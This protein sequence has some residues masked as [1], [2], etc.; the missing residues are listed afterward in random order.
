MRQKGLII[1]NK[2][3]T[4]IILDFVWLWLCVYAGWIF[5]LSLSVE[6]KKKY[7]IIKYVLK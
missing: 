1:T 6:K 3:Y 5:F 7:Y 2:V 4:K